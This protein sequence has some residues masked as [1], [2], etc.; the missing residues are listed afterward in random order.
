MRLVLA[1]LVASLASWWLSLCVEAFT[2]PTPISEAVVNTSAGVDLPNMTYGSDIV[3]TGA[4]VM[5]LYS[6]AA[7]TFSQFSFNY[8]SSFPTSTRRRLLDGPLASMTMNLVTDGRDVI[9]VGLL[10]NK[11][12]SYEFFF[13][14]FS[15]AR[16]VSSLMYNGAA[17]FV[18]CGGKLGLI[19]CAVA[20][21]PAIPEGMQ[22]YSYDTAQRDRLNLSWQKR[23][24]T[25]LPTTVAKPGVASDGV[26]FMVCSI[27]TSGTIKLICSKSANGTTDYANTATQPVAAV[28]ADA[29]VVVASNGEEGMYIVA[30]I[31]NSAI[32]TRVTFDTG[33]TW[34][35]G[36]VMFPGE[37]TLPTAIAFASTLLGVSQ[38]GASAFVTFQNNSDPVEWGAPVKLVDG[39]KVA[40]ASGGFGTNYHYAYS[41]ATGVYVRSCIPTAAPTVA[42]S[43]APTKVGGDAA[44]PSAGRWVAIAIT[45]LVM[46]TSLY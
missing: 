43:P 15:W 7:G 5:V 10:D 41:N 12:Q 23:T 24:A 2:C 21:S 19:V 1:A 45:L 36:A 27:G 25:G 16:N 17:S 35:S 33:A 8:G 18:S 3:S 26:S 40:L 20:S 28:T 31:L 39:N 37:S 14:D 11:I 38:Q 9:A 46:L 22:I 29:D 4:Y 34:A 13:G 32:E 44:V 30:F 42:P 6:T